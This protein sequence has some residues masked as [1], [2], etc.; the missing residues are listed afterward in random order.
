MEA[1][2]DR[3]KFLD[4]ES[5]LT[6]VVSD[7]PIHTFPLFLVGL[8]DSLRNRVVWVKGIWWGKGVHPMDLM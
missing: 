3:T 6:D 1:G 8:Y 7:P 4:N 5:N 2:H